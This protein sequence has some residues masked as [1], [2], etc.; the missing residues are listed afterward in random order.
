MTRRIEDMST[1]LKHKLQK[2][3]P[4]CVAF[5]LQLVESID[6]SGT[7]QILSFI[8]MVFKD[9]SVKEEFLGI[10]FVKTRATGLEIFNAFYSF[11]NK[12]KL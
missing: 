8:R 11:V 10:I 5:S 4:D 9:I 1:K 3:V 2:D 12:I 6:T 7:A